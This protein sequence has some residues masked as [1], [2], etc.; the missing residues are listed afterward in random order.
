MENENAKGKTEAT[1]PYVP[2]KTFISAL[3]SMA[4]NM[5]ITVDKSIWNFSGGIK[6]QLMSTLKFLGLLTQTSAPTTDLKKLAEDKGNRP[7]LLRDI[8]KRSYQPIFE[9]DLTKATSATFAK[10]MADNYNQEGETHRKAMSFFLQA[11]K[12]SGI[13]VSKYLQGK[14]S[15]AAVRRKNGIRKAREQGSGDESAQ[16]ERTQSPKGSVK[17]ITLSNGIELSLS[18]SADTFAMSAGDRKFVLEILE[19]MEG[20]GLTGP[21]IEKP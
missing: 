19:K 15:L 12:F 20:Y 18:A 5:P 1:V 7:V 17:T 9:H 4:S 2:F 14:G 11:A 10:V 16:V 21:N 3:D 13:P 6:S 8:L